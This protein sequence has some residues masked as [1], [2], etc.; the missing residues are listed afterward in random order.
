MCAMSF[1]TILFET[2][3]ILRRTERDVIKIYS[4]LHVNHPLFLSDFNEIWFFWTTIRKILHEN[5]SSGSRVVPCG[6]TDGRTGGQTW[7][8]K[9]SLFAIPRKRPK[10]SKCTPPN[11]QFSS[12]SF[13][14]GLSITSTYPPQHPTLRHSQRSSTWMTAQSF[15]AQQK[16]KQQLLI[17]AFFMG[18]QNIL[19]W[20]FY[21]LLT[22][23][24]VNDS[25]WMTNVTHNSFLCIY[26]YFQLS[27]CFEHIVLIIRTDKLCQ[28][29]LR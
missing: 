3:L 29:N 10:N 5:P 11:I 12:S 28:Y 19:N 8:S 9:M 1:S 24:L 16:E 15:T 23:H 2:F 14:W 25:W 7:R 26:F 21:I 22:V 20:I 18:R 27:T 17:F 6:K 13:R 4:R